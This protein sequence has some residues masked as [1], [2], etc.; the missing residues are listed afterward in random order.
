MFEQIVFVESDEKSE[1]SDVEH[2]F[3]TFDPGWKCTSSYSCCKCTTR[4]YSSWFIVPAVPS[5]QT[6]P[7]CI[8]GT[9][10]EQMKWM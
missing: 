6:A 7:N 3:K 5:V 4:S 10:R 1:S 8:S 9:T 2:V